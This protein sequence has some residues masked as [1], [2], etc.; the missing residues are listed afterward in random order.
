MLTLAES[1]GR[2]RPG[3]VRNRGSALSMQDEC[4]V[5]LPG[6]AGRLREGSRRHRRRAA[7]APAYLPF[8]HVICV[9]LTTRSRCRG[10]TDGPSHP[11][12][13]RSV[14]NLPPRTRLRAGGGPR[15]ARVPACRRGRGPHDAAD[16]AGSLA[17]LRPDRGDARGLPPGAPGLR[18]AAAAPGRVSVDVQLREGAVVREVLAEAD[19]MS[20]RAD[21]DGDAW[22]RR[23]SSR[24]PGMGRRESPAA[25]DLPR[26]R[27]AA[28]AAPGRRGPA[29]Q[30]NPVRRGLLGT[31]GQCDGVR[32]VAGGRPPG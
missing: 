26:A 19:A 5:P 18:P 14:G 13:D 31:V 6:R 7:R 22:A 2:E 1:G 25:G 3:H 9:H 8:W 23:V 28:R 24:G 16:A 15:L 12:P 11:V 17:G 30:D 20:A 32:G 27:G 4:R 29:V 21:R 10:F